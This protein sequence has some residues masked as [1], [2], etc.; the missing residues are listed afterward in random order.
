[1]CTCAEGYSRSLSFADRRRT[2]E[3][4]ER[5]LRNSQVPSGKRDRL[6]YEYERLTGQQPAVFPAEGK[7]V[8][9]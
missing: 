4:I 7:G 8:K 2:V 9:A 3:A 5:K 6:R 1:M